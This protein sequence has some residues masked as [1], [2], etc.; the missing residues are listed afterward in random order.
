MAQP[1]SAINM[2][3]SMYSIIPILLLVLLIICVYFL[4]RLDK[5][6]PEIEKEIE[7]NRKNITE[8]N[9]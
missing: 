6:M 5:E 7:K 9:A 2:I 1:E 3:R 8:E 4:S